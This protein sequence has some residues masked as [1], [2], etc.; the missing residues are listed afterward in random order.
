MRRTARWYGFGQHLV[1]R[2]APE[3]AAVEGGD[4]AELAIER[5]PAA[6]L[7]RA[8]QVFAFDQVV[9]CRRGRERIAVDAAIAALQPPLKHVVKDGGK[10]RFRFAGD[11][12][13]AESLRLS[14]A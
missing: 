1:D 13:I 9:P 8:Q 3:S 14:R 11:D 12:R 6:G 7:K 5:A 2:P 10:D 4:A